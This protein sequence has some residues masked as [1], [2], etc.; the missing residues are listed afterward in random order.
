MVQDWFFYIVRCRDNTLY[1]GITVDLEDRV[2]EHNR[3]TGAKYTSGRRPVAL[4]Y[5]EKCG[6]AS[7]ARKREYQIKRWPRAKKEQLIKGFHPLR[8]E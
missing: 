7:E 4:A 3:G 2:G 8:S 5:S 1:S 6:S